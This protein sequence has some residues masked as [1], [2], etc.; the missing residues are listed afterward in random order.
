MTEK[1]AK[2]P[3]TAKTVA[4]A[5]RSCR[6]GEHSAGRCLPQTTFRSV[7]GDKRTRFPRDN[8]NADM[9][10]SNSFYLVPLPERLFAVF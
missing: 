7:I 1:Y 5:F 8:S 9:H 3:G 4:T 10:R 2:G 6:R